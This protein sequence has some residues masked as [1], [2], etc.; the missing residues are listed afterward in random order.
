MIRNIIVNI[1]SHYDDI[2]IV[3]IRIFGN[4]LLNDL[5]NSSRLNAPREFLSSSKRHSGPL[6]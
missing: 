6:I 5:T 3:R 1:V 4:L 2:F